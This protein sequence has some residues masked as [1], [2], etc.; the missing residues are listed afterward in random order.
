MLDDILSYIAKNDEDS[1]V[2][3]YLVRKTITEDFFTSVFVIK[4][5]SDISDDVQDKVMH[6][7]FSYLDT[8]SSWQ[9]SLFNFDEIKGIKFDK[10]PNSC[11]YRQ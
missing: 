1:I 2:S 8:C 9:F 10:I 4:F 3:I 6:K 5:K 11:V 7:I